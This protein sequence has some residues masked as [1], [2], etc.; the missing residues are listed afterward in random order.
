MS[1]YKYKEVIH[2]LTGDVM[3]QIDDISLSFGG[4]SLLIEEFLSK[5][6]YSDYN[7]SIFDNTTSKTI[8]IT[9]DISGIPEIVE[10]IYHFEQGMP[11]TFIGVNSL[12]ES[13]VVGMSISKGRIKF[14]CYKA[15]E[16]KLVKM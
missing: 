11:L 4:L 1:N 14:G 5:H 10:Y 13:Y 8:E 12:S 3:W 9:C 7:L 15:K 2:P 16:G 6:Q